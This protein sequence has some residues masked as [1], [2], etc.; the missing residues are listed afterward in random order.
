MRKAP[1]RGHALLV[2]LIKKEAE[3]KAERQHDAPIF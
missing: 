2:A 1:R 3:D